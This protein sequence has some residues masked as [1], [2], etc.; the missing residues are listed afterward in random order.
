MPN[1]TYKGTYFVVN[2]S[3]ISDDV[4]MM[5]AEAHKRVQEESDADD[6]AQ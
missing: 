1:R 5:W 4:A 2:S 3:N 6:K